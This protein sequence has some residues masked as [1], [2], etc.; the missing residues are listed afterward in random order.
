MASETSKIYVQ[1]VEPA[2]GE[3]PANNNVSTIIDTG[4]GGDDDLQ[5]TIAG[6]NIR[7]ND[8]TLD[9]GISGSTAPDEA[10]TFID[11]DSPVLSRLTDSSVAN[12]GI[13]NISDVII[14]TP[15]VNQVLEF[16]GTNW[17]NGPGGS[18]GAQSLEDLDD[19]QITN[20]VDGQKIKFNAVS[21]FW[22]NVDDTIEELNDVSVN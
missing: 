20:R 2:A 13:D 1:A 18:A 19:V 6:R 14:T 12:S 4:L 3:D 8:G 15:T 5:P 21:G 10:D 7:N 11:L 17:V 9:L 16:N 22:I